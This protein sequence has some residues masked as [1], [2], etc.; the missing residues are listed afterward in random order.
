MYGIARE[1]ST[2]Y[3]CGCQIAFVAYAAGGG[4]SGRRM[5]HKREKYVLAAAGNL[6]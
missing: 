1:G 5:R 4:G 2:G 3:Y 6:R